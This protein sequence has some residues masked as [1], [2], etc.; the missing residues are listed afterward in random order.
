M[1]Y[2]QQWPHPWHE[3]QPEF[4]EQQQNQYH[5]YASPVSTRR[6]VIL[7][8]PSSPSNIENTTNNISN[9][10]TAAAAAMQYSSTAVQGSPRRTSS[11]GKKQHHHQRRHHHQQNHHRHNHHLWD[12]PEESIAEYAKWVQEKPEEEQTPAERRFLWKYMVGLLGVRKQ[13]KKD[14]NGGGAEK[15]KV[16]VERLEAKT[17]RTALEDQFI[18]HFHL[19]KQRKIHG[20]K[21]SS[22]T[23]DDNNKKKKA[24]TTTTTTTTRTPTH[25]STSNTVIVWERNTTNNHGIMNITNSANGDDD[26]TL[27]AGNGTAA[28]GGGD[29]GSV[30]TSLASLRESMKKLGLSS[31]KLKQPE[32]AP[33]DDTM[34]P[35]TMM[36]C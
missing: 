24:T 27:T 14:S 11:S 18:R 3:D 33:G 19:R 29:G 17:T 1:S 32:Q 36:D 4:T 10:A 2:K 22:K 23:D 12:L 28:A 25:H 15:T 16:F 34:E 35:M 7:A 5:Q 9:N 20:T 30:L 21:S 8:T 26:L 6:S 13:H 31:D